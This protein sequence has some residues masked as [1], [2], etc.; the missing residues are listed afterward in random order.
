M[1][2]E[3]RGSTNINSQIR[4]GSSVHVLELSRL[5]SQGVPRPYVLD[6][7]LSNAECSDILRE[8][9]FA[10]WR[11]SLTYQRQN[12]GQYHDVL[13]LPFRVSETAFQEW[14]SSELTDMLERIEKRLQTVVAFELSHL[15]GWQAIS[16]APRGHFEYHLDAGYWEG[17]HA[18]DRI[19]TFLI[20]LT[21]PIK[22]GS[23]HFRALEVDVKAKA[24]RLIIWSNLFLNGFCDHRMIH[25]GSPLLRGKKTILVTW[26]R[27]KSCRTAHK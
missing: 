4:L 14:F 9:E 3:K 12:D 16:Y 22:G 15:E 6:G 10:L 27:Q 20:Y 2:I 13:N 8:L 5:S 18:G 21:T 25:S 1:Q 11:P 19:L 17:H 7:F 23:T 26:V 24:G